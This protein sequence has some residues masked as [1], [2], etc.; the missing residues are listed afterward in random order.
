[1]QLQTLERAPEDVQATDW[2]QGFSRTLR[3]MENA[4][5]HNG[6]ACAGWPAWMPYVDTV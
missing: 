3:D 2:Y 4:R 6:N 5:E 1:M